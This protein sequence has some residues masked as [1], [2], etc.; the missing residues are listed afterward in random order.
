MTKGIVK[1]QDLTYRFYRS[2]F[3]EMGFKNK[4]E[5]GFIPNGTEVSI[6]MTSKHHYFPK[7]TLYKIMDDNGT[8]SLIMG[9]GVKLIK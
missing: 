4:N 8:E 1:R 6:L 3:T 9:R 5:N 7:V 2:K